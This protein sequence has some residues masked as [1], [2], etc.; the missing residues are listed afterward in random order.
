M[1]LPRRAASALLVV[2]LAF[3]LRDSLIDL[4]ETAFSL[5]FVRAAINIYSTR[6]ERLIAFAF[7][8]ALLLVIVFRAGARRFAPGALLA[9]A[10]FALLLPYPALARFGVRHFLAREAERIGGDDAFAIFSPGDLTWLAFDP[11]R[12]RL[13]VC[14]NGTDVVLMLDARAPNA[15]LAPTGVKTGGAQFCGFIP[16]RGE[17]LVYEQ[18]SGILSWMNGATMAV[19]RRVNVGEI[20]AAGDETYIGYDA[21]NDAVFLTS[22]SGREA[23]L[24]PGV[25]VNATTGKI[26]GRFRHGPGEIGNITMHP[27]GRFGY[28]AFFTGATGVFKFDVARRETIAAA[29]GD[30]RLDRLL[31]DVRRNELLVAS[32]VHARALVFDADTLQQKP[33]IAAVFG[34]RSL[35]IDR[36]RDKLLVTS[37]LSNELEV[38]DLESRARVTTFRLGPWLRDVAVDERAGV[39]YVT[40]RYGLYKVRFA[41]RLGKMK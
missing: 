36:S 24:E 6:H 1:K 16:Q 25:A 32:P 12:Q 26:L 9:S 31:V 22:E 13:Y 30:A 18:T 41:A 37:L 17:I 7:T 14:G 5:N 10:L 2:L 40:S 35:A 21:A 28:Y 20:A 11:V 15:R 27:N 23:G 3:L 33:P 34:A 4:L 39:A 29:K 38:I 8:A 19:T